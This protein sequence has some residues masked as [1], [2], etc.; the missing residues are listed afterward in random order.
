MIVK[1]EEDSLERCISS[2]AAAMNEII[3]VDTGS[4]DRTKEIAASLGAKVYDFTWCDDFAKAR[5]YAFSKATKEYV[6]W[7]DAD[8]Y[9]TMDNLENL[10]ELKNSSLRPDSFSMEYL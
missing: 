6:M 9:I 4:R 3:I 7:L 5:N 2:I 8:D 10:L 1:D